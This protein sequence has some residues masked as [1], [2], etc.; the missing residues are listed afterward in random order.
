MKLYDMRR[1][2]AWG[3]PRRLLSAL[4]FFMST[5]LAAS[6]LC[7]D[8]AC[9][10]HGHC[11]DDGICECNDLWAGDT[12]SFFIETDAGRMFTVAPPPQ[13]TMEVP[14]Q[15]A[16]SP[17]AP[18]PAPVPAGLSTFAPGPAPSSLAMAVAQEED[19][20]SDNDDVSNCPDFCS[21]HGRCQA[22]LCY[23]DPGWTDRNCGRQA[24]CPDD[25]NTPSGSCVDGIC[26][27]ASGYSGVS[28]A[29]RVC[30]NGCWGHGEC[31]DGLCTCYSGWSGAEC[32]RMLSETAQLPAMLDESLLQHAT[33]PSVVLANTSKPPSP[34][35]SAVASNAT[36]AV[37]GPNVAV[38]TSRRVA[39]TSDPTKYLQRHVGTSAFSRS[40]DSVRALVPKTPSAINQTAVNASLQAAR[41][42]VK[43][44]SA[45]AERTMVLAR[46]LLPNATFPVSENSSKVLASLN[47][48][49][50]QKTVSV[51][52]TSV[53]LLEE[54]KEESGRGRDD[55][56]KSKQSN[57]SGSVWAFGHGVDPA[58]ASGPCLDNCGGHGACVTSGNGHACL[59]SGGWTGEACDLEPCPSGCNSRGA[60]LRGNCVCGASFY[61]IACEF[62]R[63]LD[64]CSGHGYCESGE[65]VCSGGFSGRSCSASAL[66]AR[67]VLPPVTFS[68]LRQTSLG[69]VIAQGRSIESPPCPEDCNGNGQCAT[70][71]V[72]ICHS[73]FSGAACQ[74]FCPRF[75]S[76]KGSCVKGRCLCLLGFIGDDCS[77]E[78][79]CSG[80]GDCPMPE[81]CVCQPGWSG[82]QCHV[83][84]SCPDPTCNFRG[85]C[86]LGACHCSAGWSGPACT[87]PPH[88]CGGPCPAGGE[89][90][91]T[92]GLCMCGSQPCAS[93]PAGALGA[94]M[95]GSVGGGLAS[96]SGINS[97]SSDSAAGASAVSTTFMPATPECNSPHGNWDDGHAACICEAKWYGEHCQDKHCPDWDSADAERPECSGHGACVQGECLCAIGWGKD[98]GNLSTANLP[99]ICAH[100]VCPIDCGKRGRCE[101]GQCIC[102]MGWKG[103]ACREPRCIQDCSGHGT[104]SFLA[105]DSPA[106]CTCQ[107]GYA[108]PDCS[109]PAL[110]TQVPACPGDCSGNGLC[111]AGQ[112][113]CG[114]GFFGPDC[115]NRACPAGRTGP[116]CQ[117]AV[118]PRECN[119]RGLCLA[120]QCVC[121]DAHYG[122]DC[123]IPIQ[124]YNRCSEVCLPDLEGPACETCKGQC[125][126]L[127]N[128]ELLG[129]HNPLLDRLSTLSTASKLHRAPALLENQRQSSSLSPSLSQ[130]RVLQ[131]V[132]AKHTD[133]MTVLRRPRRRWRRRHVEVSVIRLHRGAKGVQTPSV[134]AML[135]D[136]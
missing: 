26:A 124:C 83:P 40:H 54:V 96:G 136:Q 126:T 64:D 73:G 55:A 134:Q 132:R 131:S 28:C 113:V 53:A 58:Q 11:L 7:P 115:S 121:D 104:C 93:Q 99:T 42:V 9:S 97:A 32:D 71:G 44:A 35:P 80:H 118:C 85:E 116:D 62:Y 27:C 43:A 59:C 24:R 82:S 18:V 103:P 87:Q 81:V 101:G 14:E 91:R 45:S 86:K 100:Q 78:V 48:S 122:P 107:Y 117:L 31:T 95:S 84:L 79:C 10:G 46:R 66:V 17:L 106:E 1:R 129:H 25:C 20:D 50:A 39:N 92:A 16:T 60:C 22:R 63:C 110:F 38:F 30:M 47:S 105:A 69:D 135:Q 119:G 70:G 15:Q 94:G 12:C 52:N 34:G 90:D 128:S 89:C 75:C 112:C 5:A 33:I 111:L 76:G 3:Q 68:P 21:G 57:T 88:E 108:L 65:C 130:R 56:Q 37:S 72:C 6:A 109:M 123:S 49:K 36:S 102:Q 61:G 51:R 41:D 77:V 2:L 13:A 23:C 29:L 133:T 125:L 4:P 74:D 19:D 114:D 8:P 67:E 98:M 127:S 120:G